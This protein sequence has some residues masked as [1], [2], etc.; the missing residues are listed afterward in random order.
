MPLVK[1]FLDIALFRK[2]PQ[3]V[4]ASGLLFGLAL[5]AYVLVG[6]VLLG[7]EASWPEAVSQVAVEMALLLGYTWLS[8][9]VLKLAAR[10]LQTATAML[11][12][13]ALLSSFAIPLVVGMPVASGSGAGYFLLLLLMLWH[14]GIITHILRN[15]LGCSLAVAIVLAIVYIGGT[16]QIMLLLFAP[17]A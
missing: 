16:Y 14:L 11:G 9:A 5:L 12:T 10:F 2:G 8:L 6:L 7:S 13:D 17:T 15:A 4:P 3:H 1:L